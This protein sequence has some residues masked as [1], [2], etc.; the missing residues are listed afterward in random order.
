MSLSFEEALRAAEEKPGALDE[1]G[2]AT[3]FAADGEEQLR[4]H[5][6]LRCIASRS[7]SSGAMSRFALWLKFPMS[8][9]RIA[10]LRHQEIERVMP[11]LFARPRTRFARRR[12]CYN[13]ELHRT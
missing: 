10:L 5:S 7:A 9:Q 2:L 13:A 12:Q 6:I 4:A 1:E 8:A 11:S 3:L